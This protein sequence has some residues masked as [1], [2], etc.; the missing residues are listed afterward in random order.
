MMFFARLISLIASPPIIFL[1]VSFLL[2]NSRAANEIYA[3]KWTAVS[4]LFAFLIL[5]FVGVG[6]YL[7]IFTNM[8]VSERKQ[9]PL[10]FILSFLILILYAIVILIL[11]GPKILLFSSLF[12]AFS[13][14][15]LDVINMKVKA[16]IHVA[17]ITAFVFVLGLIYGLV[18]FIFT[19]PAVFLI[20]WSRIKMGR[21]T[22]A[23]V[24]AGAV[25]GLGLT[26]IFYI[27][28]RYLLI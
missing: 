4:S 17:A 18:P 5:F 21:H 1:P 11:E 10:L 8:A 25:F 26:I 15:V 16:S 7:G 28:S 2:I 24:L 22:R 13:I 6:V 27:L 3:I 20:G 23:E 9:R 14:G 19:I 12:L